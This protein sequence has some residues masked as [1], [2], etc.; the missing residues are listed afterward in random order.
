MSLG[1]CFPASRT[2]QAKLCFMKKQKNKKQNIIVILCE[3][4][5]L[6]QKQFHS[7]LKQKTTD[8]WLLALPFLSFVKSSWTFD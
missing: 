8:Q 5:F 3:A 6:C 4:H 7:T 2:C 1:L